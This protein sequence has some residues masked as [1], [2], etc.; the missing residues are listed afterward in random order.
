MLLGLV[1]IQFGV[2]LSAPLRID[3]GILFGIHFCRIE[4]TRGPKSRDIPL[5]SLRSFE[6]SAMWR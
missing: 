5:S 1:E 2:V 6:A 4:K 3:N